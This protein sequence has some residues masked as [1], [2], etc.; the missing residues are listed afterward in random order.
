[1]N[2][3]RFAVLVAAFT[4]ILIFAGG[5]VTSTGSGLSVPDWPTTYGW[6]M[7]TFPLSKMVGGI[8]FEHTHRL[9]ASTVGFLILL[10][11]VWLRLSEPRIWVRRLGYIA[12]GAVITQGV[13][14]GITVLWYLPDPI[15][16]AHAS[17]AQ[18]VFCL[19]A[20]I[21]LVTSPG[22]T[23]AYADRGPAPNDIVLQRVAIA[24]TALI[25]LQILIGAT[26]RHT[27]AGLAI[28]D[29]PWAF[30]HLIPPHWDAKIAIHFAH[31]VGALVVTTSVLALTGHV[32]AHH[33]SRPELWRPA[34]L[35]LVLLVTQVTLGALTVLSQKQ[36]LIN[37]LHVVTGA[38]VFITALVLT[39]R[40]HRARF[41]LEIDTRRRDGTYGVSLGSRGMARRDSLGPA[42]GGA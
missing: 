2:L 41:A 32:F 30:G 18:L 17:L 20:S 13:L 23:R 4:A 16:I 36:Y 15:S 14:G 6:F 35:L 33:R 31:R 25:Y 21:A 12:L 5:L 22:W 11:A 24:T 42:G 7:F 37:S 10:L 8:R 34:L 39:L 27:D 28:P 26:M 40:S 19:T 29:F 1:M 3:H 9:I 38:S